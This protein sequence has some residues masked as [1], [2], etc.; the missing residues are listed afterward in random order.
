MTI[1]KV[2][3]SVISKLTLVLRTKLRVRSTTA[4]NRGLW[5]I[6]FTVIRGGEVP[7]SCSLESPSLWTSY[8]VSMDNVSIVCNLY[9][10]YILTLGFS[11][12]GHKG[13]CHVKFLYSIMLMIKINIIANI[14]LAQILCLVFQTK[15]F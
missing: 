7:S 8:G 14:S 11:S 15:V 2:P 13:F 5:G 12:P 9:G 1:V 4:P 10:I 6:R 3:A